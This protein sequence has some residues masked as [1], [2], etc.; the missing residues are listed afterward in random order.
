[1][2]EPR[3]PPLRVQWELAPK[4]ST[5]KGHGAK[6]CWGRHWWALPSLLHACRSWEHRAQTG[7][8]GRG[9]VWGP[10]VSRG[11]G[12]GQLSCLPRGWQRPWAGMEVASESGQALEGLNSGTPGS[13]SVSELN[14]CCVEGPFLIGT[15]PARQLQQL[16]G[17][18]RYRGRAGLPITRLPLPGQQRAL[19]VPP[20]MYGHPARRRGTGGLPGTA[21]T[22]RQSPG[23]ARGAA[24]TQRQQPACH[25][26]PSEE[27]HQPSPLLVVRGVPR[28]QPADDRVCSALCQLAGQGAAPPCPLPV[29]WELE[30]GCWQQAVGTGAFPWQSSGAGSVPAA[31][32]PVP[33]AAG[34]MSPLPELAGSVTARPQRP[35]SRAERSELRPGVLSE[36]TGP[37][38]LGGDTEVIYGLSLL[39]QGAR[40]ASVS[41][42][43]RPTRATGLIAGV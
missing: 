9:R 31:K 14:S 6:R 17:T 41:L 5:G 35:Y 42:S 4:G 30:K 43:S 28:T 25:H 3:L 20:A 39:L 18:R 33:N 32:V 37:G 34:D 12:L 1:M 2:V 10:S 27:L 21:G 16:C 11:A 26:P 19:S 40:R 29:P 8:R 13:A 38:L 15:N 36:G 24:G 22:D 7:R 23:A